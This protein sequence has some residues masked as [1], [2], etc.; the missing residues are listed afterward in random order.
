MCKGRQLIR[1]YAVQFIVLFTNPLYYMKIILRPV[2]S[3]KDNDTLVG[4]S[5]KGRSIV[6]RPLLFDS[7][8]PF[9]YH[10]FID[11]P[12]GEITVCDNIIN[13]IDVVREL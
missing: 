1:T 10:P 9:P 5:N 13:H 8:I 12:Y 11:Q 6:G 7:E 3:S 4:Y 2:A